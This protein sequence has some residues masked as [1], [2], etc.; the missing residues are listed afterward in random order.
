MSGWWATWR[1]LAE[2]RWLM[3]RRW[4]RRFG[5][6]AAIRGPIQFHAGAGGRLV[7]D[8]R[9]EVGLRILHHAT[10]ADA[11]TIIVIGDGGMLAM[12]GARIGRGST[13]AVGP[14]AELEIG[15]RSFVTD[16]SRI[17]ASRRIV[18]GRR[19]AISWGVTI[20]DDDGHGF[21]P[22][23]YTAP[24][25]IGDDVW[26]GCNVTVL[27]GVDI[28]SGS[29]VAAGAVVTRSCPPKSLL[30]GVPA[31]IIRSEVT[32]TDTARVATPPVSP[33]VP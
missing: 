23:P 13:L 9:V 1:R 21:G 14:G 25:A 26:L 15:A 24:I 33:P 27:K 29:V 28:G 3:E 32:W 22:P 11:M 18:I 31:R 2:R 17:L 10:R 6:S 30:A 4:L 7:A 5:A 20:L 16:G 19:C 12:G 8:E